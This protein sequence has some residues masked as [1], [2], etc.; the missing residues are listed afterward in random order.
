LDRD[1]K[2][3]KAKAKTQAEIRRN[4]RFK[5]LEIDRDI[6]H[7]AQI[8]GKKKIEEALSTADRKDETLRLFQGNLKMKIN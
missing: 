6:K 7:K 8:D 2:Q 4:E 1:L 5:Q 3:R